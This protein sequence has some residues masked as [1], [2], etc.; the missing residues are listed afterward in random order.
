M[1]IFAF[2]CCRNHAVFRA[3][4]LFPGLLELAC[5]IPQVDVSL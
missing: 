3:Q 4:P 2:R 5:E 1:I